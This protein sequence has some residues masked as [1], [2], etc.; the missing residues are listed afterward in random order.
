[1]YFIYFQSGDFSYLSLKLKRGFGSMRIGYLVELDYGIW[2][3]GW[4][5]VCGTCFM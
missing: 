1:M 5:M 3:G 4:G 2:G